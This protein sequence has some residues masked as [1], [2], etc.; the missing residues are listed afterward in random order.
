MGEA[1]PPIATS[2]RLRFVDI[3]STGDRFQL[4]TA[5]I[6]KLWHVGSAARKEASYTALCQFQNRI[7]RRLFVELLADG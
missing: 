5:K 6:G 7:K 4:S 1:T 2:S 3:E